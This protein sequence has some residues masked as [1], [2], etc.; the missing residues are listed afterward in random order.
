MQYIYGGDDDITID[1]SNAAELLRA[2]RLLQL[3]GLESLVKDYVSLRMTA[4]DAFAMLEA[5]SASGTS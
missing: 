2:A 4:A 1:A 3:D 5:A